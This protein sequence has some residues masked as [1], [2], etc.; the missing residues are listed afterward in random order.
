MRQH[1]I[2]R[3]TLVIICALLSQTAFTDTTEAEKLGTEL[4]PVGANPNGNDDGSIPPWNPDGVVVPANFDPETGFYPNPYANEAKL[5]SITTENMADYADNLSEGVKALLKRK[6]GDGFRLDVYPSHRDY[7][8]A[9]FLIK[10]TRKNA[11]NAR[12]V[13]DGLKI[14]Q[15]LVGYPFP[16]PKS[17]I[18]AIWNHLRRPLPSHK[19]TYHNY[20]ISAEG[21]PVLASKAN[22]F[23]WVEALEPKYRDKD[24]SKLPSFKLRINYT[25]P[26]RR[27]GEI[28][29]IHE[30]AGDYTE[31]KGRKAW[32]YLTGQRR[33]RL[34]PAVNFDTPNPG[35]AGS[36]TYDDASIFNGSPEKYNW[37]LVG[38]KEMYFP[39]NDFK[40][41][42]ETPSLELFG[43]SSIK[44]EYVRWEKHRVWV[45]EADLKE[46]DRHIYQKRRFYLDED[47]WAALS[48]ESYDQR[49]QLWRVQL[50]HP[51]FLW[52]QGL[53]YSLAY[54]AYD[55]LADIY[56]LSGKPIPEGISF[57]MNKPKN[58]FTA[59]GMARSAVR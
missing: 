8:P 43:K 37:T 6:G 45:V 26:A 38:K 12:L 30:P 40:L 9:D 17:G 10:N 46:G 25:A 27:A 28:T 36:A 13:S 52:D 35:V 54:S 44:P 33:V 34:A 24:I 32:Q 41:V 42:Y 19:I 50:M 53:T 1:S 49:G 20:Y 56:F 29:L 11:E 15:S 57:D 3:L 22:A 7:V 55:L 58:F 2:A 31:S 47:T 21:A 51:T 16:L 14:E 48:S 5:F 18:E 23:L 59:K 39:Y 4:S